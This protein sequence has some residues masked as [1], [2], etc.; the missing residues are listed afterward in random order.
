MPRELESFLNSPI[1]QTVFSFAEKIFTCIISIIVCIILVRVAAA[2]ID[3]AFNASQKISERK[4]KT[5]ASVT[6]SVIKYLLYFFT[7]CHILTVFG[8]DITS[9]IAVA[10]VGS[11]AIGFG[12]Q[13]LVQDIISGIFI[14]MEDQ[15]GVGDVIEISGLSGS[16]EHIGIRTTILRSIDG[17][18]HIIPN[19]QIKAMTN[20]S[21][22]FNRAV[23]SVGIAYEEDI[24]HVLD[25]L[26]DEMQKIYDEQ[27]IKGLM[28]V[29]VVLGVN[30]LGDSAV[31]IGISADS[32]IGENWQIERELRRI[33]KNRLA[34]EGINIPYPQSVVHIRKEETN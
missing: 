1:V 13:N 14:L 30:N 7:V 29:P 31:E 22:G 32:Q 10:S 27:A 12:A 11:V 24:D 5:L 18:V 23:V 3:K 21:K 28:A 34:K 26:K 33:I 20:M 8:V 25:V 16:V 17:N 4:R 9:I 2:V 6:K 19:G 15:Y